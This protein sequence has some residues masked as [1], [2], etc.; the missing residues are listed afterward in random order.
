MSNNN[1]TG[2]DYRD[3]HLFHH[4][5]SDGKLHTN[6]THPLP[7]PPFFH[8][9]HL[10]LTPL[11][12]S[13]VKLVVFDEA[14]QMWAEFAAEC[15]KILKAVIA[16]AKRH[17]QVLLFS[18]TFSEQVRALATRLVGADANSTGWTVLASRTRTRC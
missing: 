2:A 10:S 11:P 16:A 17:P 4:L 9:S 18:A 14:D 8:S 12:S 15:L 6:H 7:F 13:A 5:S 3:E 1:P